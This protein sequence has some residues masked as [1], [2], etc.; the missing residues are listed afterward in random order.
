MHSM[1]TRIFL[2]LTIIVLIFPSLLIAESEKLPSITTVKEIKRDG[3]FIAYNDGTV[4]DTRTSLMWA[5]KDSGSSG[6][7]QQSKD[8][9]ENYRGGGYSDW[10]MP[11][12]D[13]LAALYDQ[14]VGYKPAWTDSGGTDKVHLTDLISLSGWSVWAS[15]KFDYNAA[16]F[17]FYNG[18]KS[19]AHQSKLFTV[20]PVRYTRDMSS[21]KSDANYTGQETMPPTKSH[22]QASG[23]GAPS[24]QARGTK[25]ERPQCERASFIAAIRNLLGIVKRLQIYGT[26]E[27]GSIM[28]KDITVNNKIEFLIKSA[29]VIDVQHLP[30]ATCATTVRISYHDLSKII[31]NIKEDE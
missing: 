2:A 9:C 20:L 14:S 25:Y 4:L 19:L 16:F 5:A 24:K 18:R 22:I 27:I 3:Y 1:H 31:R 6:T 8:Y 15:E 21:N 10:R 30:D 12:A 7:W 17:H 29:E 26:E 13:E 23:L 28:S 11:M